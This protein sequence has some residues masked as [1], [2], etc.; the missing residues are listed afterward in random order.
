M[1]TAPSVHLVPGRELAQ[2][3]A[4]L[5]AGTS[6]MDPTYGLPPT[7]GSPMDPTHPCAQAALG[8]VSKVTDTWSEGQKGL[9]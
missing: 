7:S 5:A 6:P 9:K 2:H 8:D 4:V 1:S 3:P